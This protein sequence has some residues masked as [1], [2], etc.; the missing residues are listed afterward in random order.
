MRPNKIQI[1]HCKTYTLR[2]VTFHPV[3]LV[4]WDLCNFTCC[5]FHI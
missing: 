5:N 4:Y 3:Q 2:R 1:R